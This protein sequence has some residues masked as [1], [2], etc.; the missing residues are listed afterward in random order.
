MNLNCGWCGSKGSVIGDA[1]SFPGTKVAKCNS[2]HH[3]WEVV[4]KSTPEESARWRKL[5]RS[6]IESFRRKT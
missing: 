1:K 3:E 2:C 6:V 4:G 5:V